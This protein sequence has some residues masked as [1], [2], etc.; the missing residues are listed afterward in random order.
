MK[1]IYFALIF[2]STVFANAQKTPAV[3]LAVGDSLIKSYQF[4]RAREVFYS[5]IR[6]FPD[7]VDALYQLAYCHNRTGNYFDSR[8]YL[9]NAT[10]LDPSRADILILLAQTYGQL[11]FRDSSLTTYQRLLEIDTA[12]GYYCRIVAEQMIPQK[13]FSEAINLLDRAIRLNDLDMESYNLLA[14]V[15]YNLSLFDFAGQVANTGLQKNPR[16]PDLIFIN[17]RIAY[18][19]KNYTEAAELGTRGMSINSDSSR[20]NLFTGYAYYYLEDYKSCI[21]WLLSAVNDNS[22]GE[23]GLTLLANS[24]LNTGNQEKALEYID[25]AIELAKDNNLE[26][27]L[28]NKAIILTREGKIREATKLMEQAYALNWNPKILF[29]H[30]SMQ[31]NNKHYASA[32]SLLKKYLASGDAEFKKEATTVLKEIEQTM[33]TKQKK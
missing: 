33:R 24:Y 4:D 30:A 25:I 15:L 18:A 12:N 29:R 13:K 21:P 1:N 23:Q 32:R 16:N 19:L 28:Q 5:V 9:K 7:N 20:W 17:M 8:I 22:I 11:G 10:A 3:E 26:S 27:N 31:I 14:K 2:L 6:E